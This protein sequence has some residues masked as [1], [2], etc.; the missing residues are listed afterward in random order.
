MGKYS[1]VGVDGNAFS[2]MGYTARALRETGHSDLVPEMQDKAMSGDYNN[3]LCVCMEY[4]DI[5]NKDDLDEDILP[6]WDDDDYD[7]EEEFDD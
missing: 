6:D 5:A 4:V 2:V 7:P 1:L 3:L